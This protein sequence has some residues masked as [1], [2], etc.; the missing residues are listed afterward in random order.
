MWVMCEGSILWRMVLMEDPC[1]GGQLCQSIG[2]RGSDQ[3]VGMTD[4]PNRVTLKILFI[5]SLCQAADIFAIQD[6]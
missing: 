6:S 3:S 4:S 1:W 5:W 2:W